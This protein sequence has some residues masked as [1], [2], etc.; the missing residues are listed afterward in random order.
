MLRSDDAL[1]T[2]SP[3][4]LKALL[5]TGPECARST[6]GAAA[7]DRTF[8][9]RTLES[10]HAVHR[11]SPL[12][13]KLTPLTASGCFTSASGV[14]HRRFSTRQRRAEASAEQDASTS[15][16]GEK[17]T[18]HLRV[19]TACART[20]VGQ[21]RAPH[22]SLPH[23]FFVLKCFQLRPRG[24]AAA[25][26][27]ALGRAARAHVRTPREHGRGGEGGPGRMTYTSSVWSSAS[28]ISFARESND[29]DFVHRA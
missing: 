27:A 25:W 12:G 6:A 4:G 26:A 9:T 23:K 21:H 19:P 17:A 11:Y 5:Q 3:L 2:C 29:Q 22:A 20:P 7:A 8:S 16:P 18:P 1:A 15:P 24:Q 13:W 10:A 14:G 28:F